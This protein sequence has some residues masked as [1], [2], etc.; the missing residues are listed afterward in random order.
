MQQMVRIMRLENLAQ[1]YGQTR[2]GLRRTVE[3]EFIRLEEDLNF[4][5]SNGY[6][7]GAG[8]AA[9]QVSSGVSGA[10]GSRGTGSSSRSSWA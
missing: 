3:V 8:L 4:V 2:Y 1:A 5:P 10:A 9:L 6:L 7:L